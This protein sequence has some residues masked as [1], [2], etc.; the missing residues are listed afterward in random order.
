MNAIKLQGGNFICLTK[1]E[2]LLLFKEQAYRQLVSEMAGRGY[3][4]DDLRD[5]KEKMIEVSG[6]VSD[7]LEKNNDQSELFGAFYV[8]LNFYGGDSE[9]CLEL[10]NSF[11]PRR[12]R[13]VS[14]KG[15]VGVLEKSTPIDFVVKSK[16][17][18][19]L[20][21]LKRYR[22]KLDTDELFRFVKDKLAHYGN[23]LG[24]TNLL[25]ILQ[26]GG[27]ISEINFERLNDLFVK[28]ELPNKTQ[29]L[30]AYNENNKLYVINQV[31]P[32]LTT[33]RVP[34]PLNY[35]ELVGNYKARKDNLGT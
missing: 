10:K 34:F 17:G 4:L 18:V 20:F 3:T 1:N 8:F 5:S 14:L 33:S 32:G 28:S 19:R 23:D 25:I 2:Y 6:A 30:I 9:V 16:D 11:N 24:H 26:T 29:V 21:Q 27:D 13:V 7:M 15:L 12:D 22:G 35:P 31:Y